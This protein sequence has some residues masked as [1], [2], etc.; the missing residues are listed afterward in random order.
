MKR[1]L[2]LLLFFLAATH[3]YAQPPKVVGYLPY[4]R[5]S[6]ADEIAFEKLTHLC[7]AFAN[8]D[9]QG[10]LSIGGEDITPI[11][12]AGHQAGAEV[13]IS[14]GGGAIPAAATANW[15]E[16]TKPQNRSAFIG[17]IVAFVNDYDLEGV[18]MDLEWGNVDENYSGF[19]LE[20]RD[21]LVACGKQLTAAL[22]GT[23]RYPQVSDEVLF[24]FDFINV[25]AYDLTGPWDPGNPG[26]HSPYSFAEASISYW[27][28]QGLPGESLTLGLPFYGYDFTNAANVVSFT[29]GSMVAEDP[30]Y[31]QLDQVGQRYYNGIPTIE[32]KTVLAKQAAAG[33]CIWEL[34]QD[35]FNG[36]S[37]LQAIHGVLVVNAKTPFAQDPVAVYP[38]PFGDNLRIE[39]LG[40]EGVSIF[41]NRPDG[42]MIF[43]QQVKAADVLSLD[44]SQLPPGM[45]FLG[46]KSR[47]VFRVIKLVKS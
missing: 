12:A 6:L 21:S 26:Q 13:F 43:E 28:A 35:A 46:V 34:G 44:T 23:Y 18:D 24:S 41:L 47:D 4:Y 22:P 11:V 36:Y 16:L 9:M 3:F 20:L 42:R 45:Y 2:P 29:Y 37:L 10:N 1:T 25:M 5:F 31:A 17:K 39:G 7:L 14:V 32:A 8:P 15:K 27:K 40:D 19:N 38:N 30:S 33:V